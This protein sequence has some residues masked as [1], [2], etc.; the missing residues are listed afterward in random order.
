MHPYSSIDS[1]AAWKKLRFILS[2]GSDLHMT[3]NLL[4]AI[5]AFVSRVSISVSVDKTLL[6][7]EVNLSTSLRE[8]P[9]S[10][11]RSPVRLKRKYSVLCA[12]TWR[13]MPAAAR[14]R[15]CSRVSA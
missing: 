6:P 15:L 1:I 11:E 8:L 4:K 3:D 12:L 9:F 2:V 14:F 10:V 5:H 13:P 7:R